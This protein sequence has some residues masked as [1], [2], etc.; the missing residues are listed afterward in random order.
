MRE[1]MSRTEERD[2]WERQKG[3]G[4]KA[5]Q[6]F[7]VFRDIDPEERSVRAVAKKLGKGKWLLQRWCARWHWRE[8]AAEYDN[9]L[10]K[11]KRRKL[12]KEVESMRERQL[13]QARALQARGL[14]ILKAKMPEGGSYSDAVR[15]VIEGAKLERLNLG[16]ETEIV[17]QEREVAPIVEVVLRE[18]DASEKDQN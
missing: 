7:V 4:A 11:L 17:R 9:Y 18:S 2:P 16:V 5:F 6:A 8:R 10:D 1:R 15:L 3:E 14:E 12:E 13:G